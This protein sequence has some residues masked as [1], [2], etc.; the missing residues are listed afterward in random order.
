MPA[1]NV[2]GMRRDSIALLKELR[3]TIY[4]DTYPV[5]IAAALTADRKALTSSAIRG[6]SGRFEREGDGSWKMDSVTTAIQPTPEMAADAAEEKALTQLEQDWAHAFEKSDVSVFEK[7]LAKEYTYNS[8]G[9]IQNRAQTL[10]EIRTGAYKFESVKLTKLK[11]HVFG[12]VAVVT[13]IGELKGRYN[14]KDISGSA[15][16]TDFFVKRDGRWQAITTQ[17]V[18]IK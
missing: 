8:D 12:E 15:R 1:D 6:S 13:M 7:I 4:R 16:S 5:D 18:S 17:N 3:Q 14:G 10:T 11:P 2:H 9:Q